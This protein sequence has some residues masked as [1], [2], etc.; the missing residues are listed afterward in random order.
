MW[1][2]CQ[3]AA[4]SPIENMWNFL[5]KPRKQ[6]LK[7]KSMTTEWKAT[8]ALMVGNKPESHPLASIVQPTEV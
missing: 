1:S 4:S 3:F 7:N 2:R 6:T 8:V 5:P